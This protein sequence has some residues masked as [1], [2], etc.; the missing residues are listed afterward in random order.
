MSK[1]VLVIDTPETCVD[2]QFCYEL[3]EGVEAC[4]SIS[5]DDVDSKCNSDNPEDMFHSNM[6]HHAY[7]GMN[8]YCNRCGQKLDWSE[9]DGVQH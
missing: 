6:V 8:N 9:K 7:I 1:S 3:D 2:C 4:C 5:D